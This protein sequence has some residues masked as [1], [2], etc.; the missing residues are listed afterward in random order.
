MRRRPDKERE[1]TNKTPKTLQ[2]YAHIRVCVNRD[3]WW[4]L[5]HRCFKHKTLQHIQ[6]FREVPAKINLTCHR[7]WLWYMRLFE[8]NT[9][10]NGSNVARTNCFRALMPFCAF[11]SYLILGDLVTNTLVQIWRALQEW[12]EWH[13]QLVAHWWVWLLGQRWGIIGG[14][15]MKK[16]H[17]CFTLI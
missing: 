14:R 16:R 13:A 4:K 1:L 11:S 17:P 7:A 3:T 2:H 12:Y 10:H 9:Y 6:F 5:K 8:E 15:N